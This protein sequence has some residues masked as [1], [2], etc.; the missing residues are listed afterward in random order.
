M[1]IYQI[2]TKRTRENAISRRH[3][4]QTSVT[5]CQ[6]VLHF[7]EI[8]NGATLIKSFSLVIFHSSQADMSTALCVRS[9]IEL[10]RSGA[11][12]FAA[13]V[14]GRFNLFLSCSNCDLI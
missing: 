8:F 4:W 3:L 1:Q 5:L 6:N 9:E 11:H 2:P 13:K 10:C 7:V 12:R 14:L